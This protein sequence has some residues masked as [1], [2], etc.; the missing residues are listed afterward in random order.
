MSYDSIGKYRAAMAQRAKRSEAPPDEID[1]LEAVRQALP[2]SS[3]PGWAEPLATMGSGAAA[4]AVGGISALGTMGLNALGL[5]EADPNKVL[6]SLQQDYT[7]LPRTVEGMGAVYA[8]GKA[9]E[10]LHQPVA[11][12]A[13]KTLEA[14]GSPALAT[15]VDAGPTAVGALMGL[16][17]AAGKA[18][19]SAARA[20]VPEI[21]PSL[22][23]VGSSM[24]RQTGVVAPAEL[25]LGP[26]AVRRA[27]TMAGAG[28]VPDGLFQRLMRNKRGDPINP[29]E[30]W[31]PYR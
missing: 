22:G 5:S 6:S 11:W 3:V 17:G 12:A 16:P 21:G 25:L 9:F 13:N 7:Y 18:V 15:A 4:S 19:S 10:K 30:F 29:N 1:Q 2:P 24:A 14:T 20:G 8:A 26:E 31:T 27:T 23:G 28:L